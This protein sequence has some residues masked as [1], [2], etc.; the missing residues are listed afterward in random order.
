VGTVSSHGLHPSK[1][2]PAGQSALSNP[3]TSRGPLQ[4]AGANSPAKDRTRSSQDDGHAARFLRFCE[5]YMGDA[6]F[7]ISFVE[8]LDRCFSVGSP[9]KAVLD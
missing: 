8:A 6:D 1:T 3:S 2:Q 5:P 4:I 7:L 9:P